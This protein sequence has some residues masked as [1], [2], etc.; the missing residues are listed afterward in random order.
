MSSTSKTPHL[1]D[2]NVAEL[3]EKILQLECELAK[4]QRD[5]KLSEQRTKLLSAHNDALSK[6]LTKNLK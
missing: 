3:Q 4:V 2:C 6:L 1:T 5:L